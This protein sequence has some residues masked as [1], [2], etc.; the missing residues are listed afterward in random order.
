MYDA[1]DGN[2]RVSEV[3]TIDSKPSNAEVRKANK[4]IYKE[5]KIML[6]LLKMMLCVCY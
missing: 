6:N 5:G 3:I 4:P 2:A 1:V